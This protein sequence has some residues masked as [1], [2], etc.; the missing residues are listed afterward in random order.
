MKGNGLNDCN[1]FVAFETVIQRFANNRVAVYEL[2]L[3]DHPGVQEVHHWHGLIVTYQ[4]DLPILLEV[5]RVF[6]AAD[7][8]FSGRRAACTPVG[9]AKMST[10]I[11][12]R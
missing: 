10:S 3:G 11:S 8:V 1:K 6:S 2:A 4:L 7:C 12:V 9:D 5:V